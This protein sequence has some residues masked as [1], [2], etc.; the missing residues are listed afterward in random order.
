MRH[1]GFIDGMPVR[2]GASHN[3]PQPLVPGRLPV[4]RLLPQDGVKPDSETAPLFLDPA[5]GE[6]RIGYATPNELQTQCTQSGHVERTK[7][8]TL[9][10]CIPSIFTKRSKP[11]RLRYH[12]SSY[13]LPLG[14]LMHD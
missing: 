12:R 11:T 14:A 3:P 10:E 4:T 7:Y 13:V 6:P 2:E 9:S 1:L 8:G 5:T